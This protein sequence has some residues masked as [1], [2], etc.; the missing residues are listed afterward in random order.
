MNVN[1]LRAE[2]HQQLTEARLRA[3]TKEQIVAAYLALD[4]RNRR[5]EATL[6]AVLNERNRLRQQVALLSL[7]EP[8][9]HGG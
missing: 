6:Q 3:M 8:T 7:R 1:D 5:K 2:G 4:D 9:A